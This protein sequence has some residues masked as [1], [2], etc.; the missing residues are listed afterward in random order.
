VTINFFILKV[1][2]ARPS[3][4]SVCGFKRISLVLVG[5]TDPTD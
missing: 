4:V 2:M 3:F 5:P 1:S